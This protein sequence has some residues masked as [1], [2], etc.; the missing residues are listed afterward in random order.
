MIRAMLT[1]ADGACE[2]GRAELVAQWREQPASRLWLD[3]EGDLGEPEQELL[4]GLGCDPLAISD[5]KRV[6]HPPKVEC[7]D[8]NTFILFRGIA[9]LDERLQLEPQQLGI[10]V[11]DGFLITVHRGKSVSVEN[12]WAEDLQAPRVDAAA[13][14][15]LRLIHYASGRYLERLLNFEDRLADLE[16]G[17]LGNHSESEMKELVVYRSRLRKLRRIF[18]Y[19][20]RLAQ[21]LLETGSAHLGEGDGAHYHLRRDV[22]D[23]CERLYSLGSM[24]YELCGDLVEG[25]ISLSSHQLN[26]TM[27]ILTI[28]SA[29]FVPLTFLAGIYG[30]NFEYMPELQW[31]YAYFFLL[32]LMLT[33]ATAL[34]I[35][36]KRVRW[37]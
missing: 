35:V 8:A 21:S 12:A 11:G 9:S 19:H 1:G 36:F 16:D 7:F 13:E 14:R 33:V 30:M 27:K 25:Y 2:E 23:R 17:M 20:H 6:R 24:Y 31:R 15:V 4:L 34:Y 10:W 37:L 32:G 26:Q 29:I 5:C 28:I 3:I 22:F 18:S